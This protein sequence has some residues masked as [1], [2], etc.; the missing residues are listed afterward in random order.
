M[1][2]QDARPASLTFDA[3]IQS[4]ESARNMGRSQSAGQ[5]HAGNGRSIMKIAFAVA[6]TG[7][8]FVANVVY[9]QGAPSGTYSG[10]HT[11]NSGNKT[12]GLSLVIDS[13]EGELVKVTATSNSRSCGGTFPMEGTLKDNKLALSASAGH[14]QGGGCR[15]RLNLSVEGNKLTGTTGGGG[16]V[17]LSK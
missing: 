10:T 15:L 17:E 16:S 4:I 1:N 11:A 13:V 7:V 9:A 12:A 5:F 3:M 2:G 14:G 6:I 8:M